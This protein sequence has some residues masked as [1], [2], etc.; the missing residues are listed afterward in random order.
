MSGTDIGINFRSTSG[1]VTDGTDETYCLAAD[2]YP[3]TRGGWTFGWESGLDGALNRSAGVDR[4]L[5]GVIFSSNDAAP[6]VFRVDL[7]STGDYDVYAAFGDTNTTNYPQHCEIRENT[8]AFVTITDA[9]LAQDEYYD[10]TNVKRSEANWPANNA[11]TSRT[12]SSTIL[13]LAVGTQNASSASRVAHLRVVSTGGG[14][15]VSIPIAMRHYLQMMGA[16]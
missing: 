1:F 7:P 11:A 9:S 13:R 14:S 5:A 8:T 4:R 10:G 2:T 12:F 6:G 15:S 16:G 3:T